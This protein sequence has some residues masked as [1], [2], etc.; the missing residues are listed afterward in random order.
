[1]E[2]SERME[3]V[4]PAEHVTRCAYDVRSLEIDARGRV[5]VV[6]LLGMLQD[7]A[8]ESAMALGFSVERLL[9]DGISWVLARFR[10]E[11]TRWPAWRDRVTVAT[12]PSGADTARAYR[13]FRVLDGAGNEI[14]R[15]DSLWMVIDLATRRPTKIPDFV[16]I[17]RAA[18][19]TAGAVPPGLEAL[20]R[21]AHEDE[22]RQFDV[23]WSELDL[24]D[25]VNNV[26]YVDW[27]LETVPA[28][29]RARAFPSRIAIDYRAEARFGDT[30][31]ATR[32]AAGPGAFAHRLTRAAD[33]RELS[34]VETTWTDAPGRRRPR[35][36]AR[37]DDL[38]RRALALVVAAAAPVVGAAAPP[39]GRTLWRP[40]GRTHRRPALP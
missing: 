10:L 15:A 13:E 19:D 35:A 5:A 26:C 7:A 17:L 31:R 18:P 28:E 37:R 21:P 2:P 8:G 33:G 32:A 1:M 20:A 25:H 30:V 6:S 39:G 3:P 36:V 12:W 29:V 24:N 14:G 22:A 23:R 16:R 40:R 9:R 38:D 27:A 4:P 11:M 34:L